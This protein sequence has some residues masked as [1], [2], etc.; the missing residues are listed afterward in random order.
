MHGKHNS[1]IVADIWGGAVTAEESF[2]HGAAKE[3][4]Y[5]EMMGPVLKEHLVPG[6]VEFLEQ[7]RHVKRAVASNAE[8]LNVEFVLEEGAL[9]EHFLAALNGHMV[10]RPKP[11][12]EIFLRAAAAVGVAP[13]NCIV[14]EDSE[15]GVRAGRSAGARVVALQTTGKDFPEADLVIEDFR[16]A[17]LE[18]WLAEQAVR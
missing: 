2:E 9:R 11:D 14:F 6:L 18:P 7:T 17:R 5:R 8:P 16:D 12:P 10:E 15:G 4:V 1:Q 13:R 3:R